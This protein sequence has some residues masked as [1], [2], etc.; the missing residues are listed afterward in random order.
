M[1]GLPPIGAEI[2]CSMLAINS[3]IEYQGTT[4]ACDFRGGVKHRV[5]VNP[6]DPITSVRLRTVGFKV[7]AETDKGTI[8]IEQNDIDVDPK[9]LLKVTQNFPPKLHHHDV[10][11]FTITFDFRKDDAGNKR[12]EPVVLTTKQS[13]VCEANLTQFPPRGDLYKLARSVEFVDPEEP[14]K[15]IAR[16]TAFD[17]KR[18]GL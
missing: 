2:P 14:D 8:T 12:G 5:D 17:S 1:H 11:D 16:M 3:T 9:S 18:G 6:D 10:Q 7:S 13:M 4:I 15:V